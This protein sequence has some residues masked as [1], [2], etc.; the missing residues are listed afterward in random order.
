M[1]ADRTVGNGNEGSMEDVVICREI[2]NDA[3][4]VEWGDD[5]EC[6]RKRAKGHLTFILL[7]SGRL[8]RHHSILTSGSIEVLDSTSSSWTTRRWLYGYAMR[9]ACISA[10]GKD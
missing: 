3:E 6:W 1:L 8:P 2:S 5:V 4:R 9:A 7:Y 10:H